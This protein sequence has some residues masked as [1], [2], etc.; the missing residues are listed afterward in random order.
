MLGMARALDWLATEPYADAS[1][2]VYYGCSQG[3]GFG[4]YLT[5][6]YGRFAKSLILGPNKC[7]MLAYRQGREPGSFHIMNQKPENRVKAESIAPYHDNCN[8]ARMIQTPIRMVHG[9]ADDNCQ[10]VGGI[11][12]YN[13]IASKDK[14]L[15]LLPGVG[16][17]WKT[18]GYDTW[19]FA[20]P[21]SNR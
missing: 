11:A 3:G 8:F 16:H 6:L 18:A 1:R 19:L 13:S 2:F 10:T 17:D 9:T 5:A 20:P 15:R 12:A 4:L 14:E 7:D 21:G